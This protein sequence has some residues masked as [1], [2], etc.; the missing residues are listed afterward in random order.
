MQPVKRLAL[1][2]LLAAGCGDPEASRIC[3]NPPCL[4]PG[5]ASQDCL[6]FLACMAK[7]GMS[8]SSLDSTY[9]NGG[10]CWTSAQATAD[11]CTAACKSALASLRSSPPGC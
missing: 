2:L 6:D 10:V 3:A 5:R 1:M 4:V 8:N 9:G 11:S 7:Q